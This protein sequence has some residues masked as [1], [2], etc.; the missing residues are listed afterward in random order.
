MSELTIEIV[1][2]AGITY[3]GTVQSCT[4][5]GADGQFQILREHADL[6]AYLKIGEIKF[7][8]ADGEKRLA[9]SGGFLEVLKNR[10]S[11]VV[12]SAEFD[13][14]IDVE[15]AKDA[16]KRA[17]ERLAKKG[18]VDTL[19]AEMALARALNRL[20]ISSQLRS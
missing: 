14:D 17:R 4:V 12:E 5:P 2:P 18:E 8:Q 13:G 7:K 16:E 3:R 10:I 19:R 11:L 9:T 15:R 1:T 6:L 20:K